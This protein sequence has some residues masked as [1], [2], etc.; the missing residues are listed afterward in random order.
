MKKI[1]SNCD[2]VYGCFY[3]GVS[4]L[5]GTT[6]CHQ[7]MANGGCQKHEDTLESHGFCPKCGEAELNRIEQYRR[8]NERKSS[9]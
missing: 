4:A 5:C 2:D 1:C 3:S 9:D 6:L 7:I 8:R